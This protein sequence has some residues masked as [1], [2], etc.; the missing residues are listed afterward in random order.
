MACITC[1]WSSVVVQPPNR[2]AQSPTGS[3]LGF[4][5]SSRVSWLTHPPGPPHPHRRTRKAPPCRTRTCRTNRPLVS[6]RRLLEGGAAVFGALAL[7]ASPGLAHASKADARRWT[8]PRSGTATSPSPAGC[9]AAAQHPH[10]VP[11]RQTGTGR[12]PHPL[13]LPSQ[14]RRQL[15]VRLRRTPTTATSTSTARTWTTGTGSPSPRPLRLAV[16]RL[17]PPDLHQHHLPMVGPQRPGRGGASHRPPHPPQPRRP[18][19]AHLHRPA[20]LGRTADVSPL[21]SGRRSPTTY[22]STGSGS[23][24]TRLLR[25]RRVPT[26]PSTSSRAPTRSRSGTSTATPT[27]TGS[28]T[29]T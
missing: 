9:R 29:R 24:I 16:A 8:A 23:A 21:R 10:A 1:E 6:R 15:E 14:P 27:A 3:L 19:P 5:A 17:R 11:G 18:V 20:R 2:T 7:S 28:R 25:P 4:C 13:A 26:S 22:R 12:R